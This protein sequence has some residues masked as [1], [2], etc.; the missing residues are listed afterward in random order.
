MYSI[1]VFTGFSHTGQLTIPPGTRNFSINVLSGQ[2]TIN[3][4]VCP[5]PYALTVGMPDSKNILSINAGITVGATGVGN[6]VVVYYN[7]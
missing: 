4:T 2:A 3:S 5:A 7:N 1:P 6:R